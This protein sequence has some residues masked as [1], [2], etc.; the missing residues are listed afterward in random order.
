MKQH[1]GLSFVSGGKGPL[2][3]PP[4][5]YK[6]RDSLG[7]RWYGVQTLHGYLQCVQQPVQHDWHGTHCF[8]V[9]P[10]I[11]FSFRICFGKSASLAIVALHSSEIYL[12]SSAFFSLPPLAN[13][14]RWICSR[15]KKRRGGKAQIELLP[16][17][18]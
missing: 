15:R 1:S 8:S 17:K 18:Q 16:Q 2:L 7:G 9:R 6:T 3:L 14:Q 10:E 13:D 5:N 4:H 11:I 12:G